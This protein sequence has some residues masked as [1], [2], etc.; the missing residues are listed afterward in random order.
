MLSDEEIG[1]YRESEYLVVEGVFD[2]DEVVELSRV[3]G[4]FVE[5][6]GSVSAR[7]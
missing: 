5:A 6:S 1:F 3:T 4:E 7:A 2:E